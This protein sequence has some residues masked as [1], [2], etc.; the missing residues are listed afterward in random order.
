[1]TGTPTA[2]RLI[3]RGTPYPLGAT[4]TPEGVNFAL[5]SENSRAVD[6]CL[7]D[8]TDAQEET[9][10]IRMMEQTEHVWHCFVPGLRAGQLYGYRVYGLY[11]PTQGHRFNSAKVLI[12]PYARAIAGPVR[13]GQELY[14]Y[15]HDGGDDRD[16]KRDL[17][18]S[19]WGVPKSVVVDAAFDWGGVT[20]PRI[21]LADSV[22]YEVHVK[23][24]TKLMPGVPEHLRG[25]YAGLGSE[26]AIGYLKHLG[27]TAVELLPIH[28]FLDEPF[29]AEKG[30]SNY[31]GYSS[32]GFFAPHA[33]YAST[34]VPG[35]QVTEF[36]KMVK[37]L[38]RA[39][40]EVILDVVYNHTAEGNHLGP[41]VCFRGIDNAAYYRLMPDHKRFCRDYTGCGNTLNTQHPRV[42]QLIMDSL[43]YWVTEMHVDGFRF[44]LAS[45]LAREDHEVDPRS[46]FFDILHQDPVLSRVKLIAEP[47]DV[48]DGGYWVGGFPVNWSEWNGK[49]RDCVRSY[50]KG[51]G[52]MVG[53]FASRITGSSDL[54]APGGRRPYASVNFI[55]AHDGFT[56]RD[57]VSY[58]EKHNEQN[59]EENRDGDNHNRSW[60]SGAEGP[61]DDP[62]IEELRRRR[63]RNFL[64]TLLLSQGVPML[65]AGDELGRT[66]HGN[67]NAYCQ[68]NELSWIDWSPV[69]HVPGIEE[70]T[71][72]L[73]RLR[74][75]HPIFRRTKFFLGRKIRGSRVKDIIWLTDGGREMT[76]GEWT[77]GHV[78]AL[79]VVLVGFASDVR[80]ERGEPIK[81][82]TFMLLFNAHHGPVKFALA[83]QKDV[84]W[85]LFLDTADE[86][87]FLATPLAM[88]SGDELEL[89]AY[90]ACA[91][92]LTRGSDEHARSASWKSR[93]DAAK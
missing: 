90:S 86:A 17:R 16:L 14:G 19:A 38:H 5:F 18:D 59:R 21:P 48:G 35:G 52:G 82:D 72:R 66:Q 51:D 85:E 83:G 10:R 33:G 69:H 39:G 45:A 7:F 84:R 1:M 91:L 22:I 28:H 36:K 58:N 60:N 11:R 67:N 63:I 9:E 79:G 6:L 15:P 70:F 47:W 4:L 75:K 24:F 40:I 25:T 64:F 43:R 87:G 26:R 92:R 49:Y 56:L 30:L 50:W 41:T 2:T 77:S 12:D 71:R 8:S 55:T 62:A 74:H 61:T 27:V 13:W 76:N 42:L 34:D 80:D 37:A 78:R 23:G 3:W 81:D 88:S 89:V 73:I 31:W 29:L 46:G 65:C 20:P 44:D 93:D 54:Y 53:E 57:L 68:D 32:I